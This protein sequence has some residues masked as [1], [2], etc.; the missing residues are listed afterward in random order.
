MRARNSV[1]RAVCAWPKARKWAGWLVSNASKW[2][3][4]VGICAWSILHW[5]SAGSARARPSSGAR[6]GSLHLTLPLT[7]SPDP[8]ALVRTCQTPGTKRTGRSE[9]T[10]NPATP[11]SSATEADHGAPRHPKRARQTHGRHGWLAPETGK[12]WPSR[13]G[14]TVAR[15]WAASPL[16]GPE[17]NPSSPSQRPKPFSVPAP[18]S[19]P[20]PGIII[21]H[22]RLSPRLPLAAK[23]RPNKTPTGPVVSGGTVT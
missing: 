11:G 5:Q 8:C 1:Q 18:A 15:L 2:N 19:C 6:L 20:R 12:T 23:G 22:L 13:R 17:I 9:T 14:V 3:T 16:S 4:S 10:A 7:W 21:A